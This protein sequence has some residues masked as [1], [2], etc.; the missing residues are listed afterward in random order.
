MAIVNVPKRVSATPD[1]HVTPDRRGWNKVRLHACLDGKVGR[2]TEHLGGALELHNLRP[3][4]GRADDHP[5]RIDVPRLPSC[6]AAAY[7]TL[8]TNGDESG[9]T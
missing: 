1:A 6:A 9:A 7:A 4:I 2:V 5:I 8:M 3:F